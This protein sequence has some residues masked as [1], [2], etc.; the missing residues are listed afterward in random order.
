M[1]WPR[2]S[3]VDTLQR[4]AIHEF[5]VVDMPISVVVHSNGASVHQTGA[6]GGK[7]KVA[8]LELNELAPLD[9]PLSRGKGTG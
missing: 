8:Y 4:K 2:C 1:P 3:E 9:R 6:G 5:K 7:V